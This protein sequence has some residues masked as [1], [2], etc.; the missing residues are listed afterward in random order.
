MKFFLRMPLTLSYALVLLAMRRNSSSRVEP[1][2]EFTRFE[3]IGSEELKRKR[4]QDTI[5]AHLAG[6]DDGTGVGEDDGKGVGIPANHEDVGILANNDGDGRDA[7]D[8]E[9][10]GRVRSKYGGDSCSC[11]YELYQDELILAIGKVNLNE[12]YYDNRVNGE[13]EVWDFSDTYL[14]IKGLVLWQLLLSWH[15]LAEGNDY[16]AYSPMYVKITLLLCRILDVLSRMKDEVNE[17]MIAMLD[18][19]ELDAVHIFNCEWRHA[20]YFFRDLFNEIT[21]ESLHILS[22]CMY[23]YVPP[24]IMETSTDDDHLRPHD[25][26]GDKLENRVYVQEC[27]VLDC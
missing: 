25:V 18:D 14:W 5:L 21:I 16:R 11:L 8:T 2:V 20:P 19:F 15:I 23:K 9:I 27:D 17:E 4:V 26:V 7:E 12:V 24:Y 6:E 10:L 22:Q 13:Q 3:D 1:D